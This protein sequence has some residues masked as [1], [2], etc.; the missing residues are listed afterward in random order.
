[1]CE[2]FWRLLVAFALT[3]IYYFFLVSMRCFVPIKICVIIITI[4]FRFCVKELPTL[5]YMLI[6]PNK[7][8]FTWP[9]VKNYVN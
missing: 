7:K 8:I 5:Y 4:K 3:V 9:T 1:M 6:S 2:C